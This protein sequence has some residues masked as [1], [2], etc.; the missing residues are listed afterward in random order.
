MFKAFVTA[1]VLLAASSAPML[2]QA[3]SVW[4]QGNGDVVHFDPQHVNSSQTRA[5][6]LA[7]F[8][9]A[10][11]LPRAGNNAPAPNPIASPS[12]LSRE[13]V[14]RELIQMS[15]A[16]KGRLNALFTN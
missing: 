4:H 10:K 9:P 11:Q 15:A 7:Q 13:Q 1:T 12:G 3:E 5:V 6:V 8:T 16:E 14:V 2:A